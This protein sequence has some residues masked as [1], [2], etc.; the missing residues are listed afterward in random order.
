M[1]KLITKKSA[2]K[3]FEG[4]LTCRLKKT[5]CDMAKPACKNCLDKNIE[6]GGFDISLRW[7]EPLTFDYKHKPRGVKFDCSMITKDGTK[8]LHRRRPIPLAN[9]NDKYQRLSEFDYECLCFDKYEENEFGQKMEL[10][11]E[12]IVGPFTVFKA[13][14]NQ[15]S[16]DT[17]TRDYFNKKEPSEFISEKILIN[18]S[19]TGIDTFYLEPYITNSPY[20]NLS[21]SEPTTPFI[22][23]SEDEEL[24]FSCTAASI[25]QYD[26]T[27]D[28]QGI[29]DTFGNKSFVPF[30]EI[31]QIDHNFLSLSGIF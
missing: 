9:W 2:P 8:I 22:N 1:P 4:C 31:N 3:S 15:A 17:S 30:Q 28:L 16:I 11:T 26:E 20:H 25:D 12:E 19:M 18:S 14:P 29:Q 24:E 23:I 10:H 13:R 21:Y 7:S 5:R 27:Y 6:C